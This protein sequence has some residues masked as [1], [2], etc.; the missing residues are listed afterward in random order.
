MARLQFQ[1]DPMSSTLVQPPSSEPAPLSEGARLLDV[2]IAPAK[3]FTDLRRSAMWWAPFLVLVFLSITFTRVVDRNIGFQKVVDNQIQM[4]PKTADR[5]EQ[6]SPEDREKQIQGR[7][8]G[9]RYFS[10]GYGI[11]IL[12]WNLVV[13]LLLFATFKLVAGAEIKF[14]TSLAIIMYASLPLA[15]RTVLAIAS[16]LAGVNADSFNIQNSVATNLGYFIDP[17]SSRFLYGLGSAVDVFMIWSLVLTAIGFTSVSKLKRSTALIGV[18]GWYAL[19]FIGL[20]A[21]GTLA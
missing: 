13:A 21:L 7:V 1:E 15:L 9:T 3:T 17:N 5:L 12:L 18:F 2:F 10:Y 16:V 6:L 8:V 19:V 11:L 4:S 14:K 20:A